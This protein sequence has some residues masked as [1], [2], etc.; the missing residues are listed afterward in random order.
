MCMTNAVKK[1]VSFMLALTLVLTSFYTGTDRVI[2]NADDQISL[3]DDKTVITVTPDPVVYNGGPAEPE[4]S[5]YYD[6][7]KLTFDEDYTIRF[8]DNDEPGTALVAVDGCG[9]YTGRASQ[10]F[11][12]VKEAVTTTEAT[13]TTEE[14]TTEEPTTTEAVTTAIVAT[15]TQA[16]TTTEETIYTVEDIER[17]TKV[18]LN[19]TSVYLF[20]TKKRCINL[21][22][23][24]KMYYFNGVTRL[25]VV[26][27]NKKVTYKSSSSHVATV[28]SKGKVT[29]KHP[30]KCTI[31]AK[32][33]GKSFKCKVTVKNGYSKATVKKNFKMTY[34]KEVKGKVGTIKIKIQNKFNHPMA[35]SYCFTIKRPKPEDPKVS[36]VDYRSRGVV[37]PAKSTFV[38]YER[39]SIYDK[40]TVE[41]TQKDVCYCNSAGITPDNGQYSKTMR[42]NLYTYSHS[43]PV[44]VKRSE[45]GVNVK[46]IEL[47]LGSYNHMLYGDLEIYNKLAY[48]IQDNSFGTIMFYKNNKLVYTIGVQTYS[49]TDKAFGIEDGLYKSGK[50]Y[51]AKHY[52]FGTIAKSGW[53]GDY[54][55]WEFVP[56]KD[57]AELYTARY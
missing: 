46:N 15:T 51:T 2:V 24:K 5:V 16:S 18:H 13:T 52:K 27:T 29:A 31:T 40:Q 57:Y 39:Y 11:K 42:A 41:L 9:R 56:N 48:D 33:G 14:G 45:Y 21:S 37:V 7:V 35:I 25:H 43:D 34:T 1:I 44:E 36:Y 20:L 4:V 23:K 55:R 49:Y 47:K 38:K 50:K 3:E 10:F 28:S 8:Y 17:D 54:D 12:I 19:R 22:N 53:D 30:G 26:N 32:V 6:G